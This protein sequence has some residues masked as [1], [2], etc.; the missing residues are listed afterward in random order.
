MTL[1]CACNLLKEAAEKAAQV[2]W[3]F[4]VAC[5]KLADVLGTCPADH[6]CCEP[7]NCEK[8]CYYGIDMGDCWARHFMYTARRES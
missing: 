8:E 2:E 5:A 6:E 1:D 4:R 3:E 7:R